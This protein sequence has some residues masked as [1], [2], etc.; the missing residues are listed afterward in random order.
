MK[1]DFPNALLFKNLRDKRYFSKGVIIFATALLL[2]WLTFFDS[3]SLV[4]RWKWHHETVALMEKNQQLEQDIQ[5]LKR[6]L[7]TELPDE[8]I[9]QMARERYGMRKEGETVYHAEQVQ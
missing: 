1:L 6:Q 4:K 2:V 3:H 5:D 8:V 7:D 9:E